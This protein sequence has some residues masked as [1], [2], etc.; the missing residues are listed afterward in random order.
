MCIGSMDTGLQQAT[1]SLQQ[2]CGLLDAAS[3][4]D[5]LS[6]QAHHGV[7]A[8]RCCARRLLSVHASGV[9]VVLQRLAVSLRPASSICPYQL[10]LTTPC[11]QCGL[12]FHPHSLLYQCSGRHAPCAQPCRQSQRLP[13]SVTLHQ[14]DLAGTACCSGQAVSCDQATGI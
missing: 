13:A 7:A 9:S 2:P 10:W 11:S 4:I 6:S 14:T 3:A 8:W 5:R 1:I 12:L